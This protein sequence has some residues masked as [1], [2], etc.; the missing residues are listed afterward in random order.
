MTGLLD[1]IYLFCMGMIFFILIKQIFLNV[2][3][4]EKQRKEQKR[5]VNEWQQQIQ[6]NQHGDK[7]P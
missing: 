1:G 2:S 7:Q 6:N 4:K 5:R 3:K